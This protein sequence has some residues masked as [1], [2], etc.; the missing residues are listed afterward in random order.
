MTLV[1]GYVA[2]WKGK[3]SVGLVLRVKMRHTDGAQEAWVLS[4][5]TGSLVLCP[6][7]PGPAEDSRAHQSAPWM[8]MERAVS[9]GNTI[10]NSKIVQ[11]VR[12]GW[13]FSDW[14]PSWASQDRRRCLTF[15]LK[16]SPGWSL[17]QMEV[18]RS[19]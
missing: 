3:Q 10:Q 14:V 6:S 1:F 16:F 12:L 15:C 13:L 17:T 2:V 18:G 11:W 9:V 4:S 5:L 19:N 7:V 8:S